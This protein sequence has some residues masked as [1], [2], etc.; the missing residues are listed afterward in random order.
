MHRIVIVEWLDSAEPADNSDIE[1]VDFP[2]PQIITNIGYLVHEH[3]EYVVIAG[4]IKPDPNGTTYDYVIAIPRVAVRALSDLVRA[5]ET[6]C[7]PDI[8]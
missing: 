3:S 8:K 2:A 1:P 6:K 7:K 5:G 4:G